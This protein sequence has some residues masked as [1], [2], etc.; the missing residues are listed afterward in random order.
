V[1]WIEG[2]G[3]GKLIL[4]HERN[5][6]IHIQNSLQ[7]LSTIFNPLQPFSTHFNP[8]YKNKI[9]FNPFQPTSTNFTYLPIPI[10]PRNKHPLKGLLISTPTRASHCEFPFSTSKFVE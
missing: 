4:T 5:R 7:P 2:G 10:Y 9:N 8:P 6:A 1:K 3:S